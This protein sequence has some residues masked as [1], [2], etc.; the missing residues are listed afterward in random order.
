M[1]RLFRVFVP[2]STLTL[3]ISE[4]LLIVGAYV[5]AA[6]IVLQVDPTTYLLYDGGMVSI[7]SVLISILAALYLQDL[8]S[9]IYVKSGI[10]L[11]QQLCLAAGSALLIQGL[12]SYVNRGMRMPLRMMLV[13][14]SLMLIMVFLWRLFF[15]KFAIRVVGRDRLLLL[16]SSPLLDDIARHVND[17]PEHGIRV[18]GRLD[19][20]HEVGSMWNGG[21][22]LGRLETLQEVVEATNPSRIVVGMSERRNRIPVDRTSGLAVLRPH[23]RRGR[24]MLRKDL[25]AGFREGITP[26][27]AHLFRRA[28]TAAPDCSVP[29]DVRTR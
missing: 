27:A 9:D 15:S 8:Y 19:D 1:I 3:L 10:A 25:R 20:I 21:K 5:F 29:G 11:M 7:L 4:A 2:A 26:L 24:D 6:Y 23:H 22:I 18:A 14:S 28:W 16:G 17:H 13:G 12:V